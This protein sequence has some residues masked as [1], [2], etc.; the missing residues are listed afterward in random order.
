MTY[1]LDQELRA[2]I[3]KE[4][5]DKILKG[6]LI[7]MLGGTAMALCGNRSMSILSGVGFIG[8]IVGALL[9]FGKILDGVELV[10][11]VKTA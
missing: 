2:Y 7:L 6:G 10:N 9:G 1:I 8:G 5:T 3:F 11:A 4:G